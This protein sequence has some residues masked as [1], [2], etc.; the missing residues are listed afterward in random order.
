MDISTYFIENKALFGSYPTNDDIL[1]FEK[2]LGVKYFVDLTEHNKLPPY[3]IS[4][5]STYIKFPIPDM[6]IPT[7]TNHFCSFIL[8]LENIIKNGDKMYVHCRGGN[9]RAG[10]VVACLLVR[11]HNMSALDAME[12][13]RKYH[14]ERKNLKLKWRL[15]GSPQTM[16]Q[17]NFIIKLFT[18]FSVYRDTSAGNKFGFALYSKTAIHVPELNM[19]FDTAHN[20][21]KYIV[22]SIPYATDE[23][24]FNCMLYVQNLKIRQCL[25]FRI[26]LLNTAF[27]PIMYCNNHD[28]YWGIDNRGVGNNYLGKIFMQLRDEIFKNEI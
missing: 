26:N 12:L 6:K 8:R 28:K 10:V 27:R 13:T 25:Q 24:M 3:T 2:E 19:D 18:P 20:A 22:S 9:G 23:D 21:Y 5:Q 17:K 11:Y 4:S 1:Y 16:G 7:N 14:S 15:I